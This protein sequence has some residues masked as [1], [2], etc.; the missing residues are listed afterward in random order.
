MWGVWVSGH[1]PQHAG[2]TPALLS[3][4]MWRRLVSSRCHSCCRRCRRRRRR[5]RHRRHCPCRCLRRWLAAVG[6]PSLP[7]LRGCYCPVRCRHGHDQNYVTIDSIATAEARKRLCDVLRTFRCD[8]SGVTASIGQPPVF[9]S[10]TGET[11]ASTASARRRLRRR[12]SHRTAPFAAAAATYVSAF[13][14]KRCP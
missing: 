9:V 2:A 8:V 12:C 4:R 5:S 3:C 1:S 11:T 14:P 10:A 6:P 13:G 7:P